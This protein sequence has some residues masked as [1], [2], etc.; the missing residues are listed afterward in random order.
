MF[1]RLNLYLDYNN[2][3]LMRKAL[4]TLAKEFTLALKRQD[5]SHTQE[6][7][8]TL[9][10]LDDKFHLTYRESEDYGETMSYAQKRIAEQ[11]RK[12]MSYFQKKFAAGYYNAN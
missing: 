6:V 8:N 10:K 11:M 2:H 1:D 12:L 4:N 5:R 9:R 3:Y 7:I